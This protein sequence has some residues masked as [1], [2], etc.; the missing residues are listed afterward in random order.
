MRSDGMLAQVEV[1]SGAVQLLRLVP[2]FFEFEA[3]RGVWQAFT[4]PEAITALTAILASSKPRTYKCTTNLGEQSYET[5]LMNEQG[6]MLQR[7][8]QSGTTRSVRATPVGPD[9]QPHFEY[10]EREK[11][12]KPGLSS[13]AQSTTRWR[14]CSRLSRRGTATALWSRTA[15]TTLTADGF[16]DQINLETK[17]VRP[18]RPAPW[19]GRNTRVTDATDSW[20]PTAVPVAHSL[21]VAAAV[22][23]AEPV[24][25]ATPISLSSWA[26][27]LWCRRAAGRGASHATRGQLLAAAGRANGHRGQPVTVPL[28]V[29]LPP[30]TAS[31]Y[32]QPQADETIPMGTVIM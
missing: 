7:N 26:A 12:W 22:P 5:S 29:T 13:R 19:L 31:Y 27:P 1:A 8:L 9:G 28:G 14:A 15:P 11:N 23:Q 18:I 32:Y 2:F 3:S 6:M 10:L 20:V 16:I 21:P 4:E 30:I 25:Q 17:A 24:T